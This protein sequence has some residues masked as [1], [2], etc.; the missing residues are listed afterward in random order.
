MRLPVYHNYNTV[1]GN[2]FL[3]L[4]VQM[5]SWFSV[6]LYLVVAWVFY[7]ERLRDYDMDAW[8]RSWYGS[9]V[10]VWTLTE[11]PR[12]F[13]GYRGNVSQS[14][15]HLFGFVALT[16]ITHFTLVGAYLVLVPY[17]NSLDFSI[18]VVSFVFGFFE[19][20]LG[21]ITLRK[22][23]KRNTTNFYVQ[24][25]STSGAAGGSHSTA[26]SSNSH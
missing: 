4:L 23:I 9:I 25:G 15:A 22:I 17:R 19:A 13:F 6:C 14:V 24:L 18:A 12:L 5:H 10:G 11:L 1:M 20:I 26:T 2:P 8:Q 16:F 7:A 21:I 3:A